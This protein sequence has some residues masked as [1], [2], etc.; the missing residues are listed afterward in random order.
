V[1]IAICNGL[2][3]SHLSRYYKYGERV[4]YRARYK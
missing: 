1:S 4:L 3:L 2:K